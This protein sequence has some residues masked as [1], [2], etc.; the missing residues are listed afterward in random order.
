[1]KRYYIYLYFSVSLM[2]L[3]AAGCSLEKE[4]GFNRRMQNLTARYN[5]LFNANELLRIKQESYAASFIDDYDRVLNVYQDTASRLATGDKD[6]DEVVIKANNIISLKEQ[7]NYIDD[8]YLLLAKAAHLRGDYYNAVE[9]S[10]YIT[11][12]FSKNAQIVQ[13]ARAW[14]IRS[15]LYLNQTRQAKAVLDTAISSINDKQK[16][17]AGMVYAAATQLYIDTENYTE[18]IEMV[19]SAIPLAE[20]RQQRLRWTFILAQLQELTRQ[21]A[22][23][24]ENYSRIVKSN[25]S[26]VMAFNA[27]LNRIRIDDSNNGRNLS[28]ADRLKSLLRNENNEEFKDQIY[29]QLGE[30]AISSNETDEAIKNYGLSVKNSFRNQNQKGLSYLRLADISFK[31]KGDYIAA[32]KYYDSTLVSLSPNYPGYETIKTK[33]DNLQLIADKLQIIAREDTLQALAKLDTATRRIRIEE[34]ARQEEAKQ[35]AT[36][37]EVYTSNAS[38]ANSVSN[39]L[40]AVDMNN[41]AVP[42]SSDASGF[43]FD[44]TGAISQGFTDFKR[45]WGNRKLED[46]WRRSVRNNSNLTV[47]TTNTSQNVDAG[48]VTPNM[49]KS[50]A[51]VVTSGVKQ[52]LLQNLPLTPQ[53]LESSN[54]RIYN[55]YVDLAVFYRDVLN[56]K[57]EAIETFEQLLKRFP[58]DKNLAANYYNLYR[59]YATE[60]AARSNEYKALILSKYPTSTFAKVITDPDYAQR[61]D[62]KDAELNAF[63]NQIYDLYT[64]RQYQQV[65]TR[66]DELLRQYT[67]SRISPQLAY[68]RALA[69]GH[70]QKVTPFRSELV[71]ITSR[72]P[73]DG[74]I[75]PLVRQHLLYIDANQAEMSTRR[76]AVIDSDPNAP[77]FIPEPIIESKS[78]QPALAANN[79]QTKQPEAK[80]NKPTVVEKTPQPAKPTATPKAPVAPPSIFGNRDS[81]N[82]LFVINVSS[83]TTNLSSSRFGVG[84]FNRTAYQGSAVKHQLKP[85]GDDNQLIYVGRFTGVDEVKEYARKIIPLLP[86]IM[87]VPADKYSFFIIT[88]ENLDKL[89]DRKLLDSYIEYYQKN[90]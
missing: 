62:N 29:Y 32:R 54:Q 11:R 16:A 57:P 44:N 24:Y 70:Q 67:D 48:V 23:A 34:M 30:L 68:L 27:Q 31:T 75:T 64:Q 71:Q 63:Y 3:L 84:Q 25:A 10:S 80:T 53:L 35:T 79:L 5:I 55:A 58:D 81:S 7:S 86:Q 4:S 41:G 1:M 17:E 19:K 18:A 74:L 43:Y 61:L 60:N 78:Q 22:D 2:L 28:R 85:V 21:P 20:N 13:Q 77:S 89:A 9:Y 50:T 49:Q 73:N 40:A 51:D 15:L 87:K 26:F 36:A 47:N 72:Y 69:A 88:Q 37:T 38:L 83:G 65:I 56:D 42:N 52:D 59:L 66:S 90:F 8:A 82:Y 6:L 33:A 76:F 12:S 39:N 45:K 46:N 14:Q